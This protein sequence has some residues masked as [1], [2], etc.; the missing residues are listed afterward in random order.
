MILL[1]ASIP[2]LTLRC[3]LIVDP[4][5]LAA[6]RLGRHILQLSSSSHIVSLRIIVSLRLSHS[7]ALLRGSILATTLLRGRRL[8]PTTIPLHRYVRSIV[9]SGLAQV[10][11]E[12]TVVNRVLGKRSQVALA[13]QFHS[14][15]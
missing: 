6:R 11:V 10:M 14:L 15:V 13:V 9:D 12:L 3:P 7:I 8:P 2:L 5:R 1:G 4:S